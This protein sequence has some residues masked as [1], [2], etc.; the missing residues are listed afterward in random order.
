MSKATPIPLT[1]VEHKD[2]DMTTYNEETTLQV[3]D[4]DKNSMDLSMTKDDTDMTL[5]EEDS[6]KEPITTNLEQGMK[7]RSGRH[8]KPPSR[9]NI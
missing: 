3:E 6:N 7:T 1:V 4:R 2:N 5:V 9:F 8:V